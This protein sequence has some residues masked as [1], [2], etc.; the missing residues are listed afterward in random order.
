VSEAKAQGNPS[1][2]CNPVGR[3]FRCTALNVDGLWPRWELKGRKGYVAWGPEFEY[4]A[5]PRWSR[6]QMFVQTD[7]KKAWLVDGGEVRLV[8]GEAKLRCRP[9]ANCFVRIVPKGPK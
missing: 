6:I 1:F 4:Y 8:R 2:T 5:P 7:E 9:E 3:M